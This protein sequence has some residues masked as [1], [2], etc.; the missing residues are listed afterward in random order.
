MFG[1]RGDVTGSEAGARMMRTR[2]ERRI[3]RAV[4]GLGRHP[5]RP[6]LARADLRDRQLHAGGRAAGRRIR[7]VFHAF[8]WHG[9]GVNGAQVG[10]RLLADVI[11]G[12]PIESIPSP[13]RG[14]APRLPLPGLRPLYVGLALAQQRLADALS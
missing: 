14:G 2:L 1:M 8:G 13:W 11:A 4:P 10:G 3:G 7:T 12:A 9:S 5:A 6:F